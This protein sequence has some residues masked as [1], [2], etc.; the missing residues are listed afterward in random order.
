MLF[1]ALVLLGAGLLAGCSRTSGT[2]TSAWPAVPPERGLVL[3]PGDVVE[4]KFR[5]NPEL[6]ESQTVRP[7]GRISLQVVDEVDVAGLTP[8][9]LDAKLTKLYEK[10][11]VQPELTVFLRTSNQQRVYVGGEVTKPGVVAM[12]GKMTALEAVIEAGGFNNLTAKSAQTIVIRHADGKRYARLVDLKSP[13][14]LAASD[15][16]YLA[17]GDV[18]F[19]PRTKISKV[20]QFVD[21]YIN[22]II[23]QVAKEVVLYYA[24]Q[25]S[26]SKK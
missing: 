3:G 23:P 17:P 19:V 12:P 1:T 8:K 18:V 2:V 16:F 11:L 10:D 7:D 24:I 5:Y 13:L 9:E 25:G 4:V 22:Q 15:A 26:N 6:N 14:R 20:D 21:Q